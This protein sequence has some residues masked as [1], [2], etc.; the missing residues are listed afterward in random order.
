[1]SLKT[2]KWLSLSLSYP[3]SNE[4]DF[5]EMLFMSGVFALIFVCSIRIWSL[6]RLSHII[7]NLYSM[8]FSTLITERELLQGLAQRPVLVSGTNSFRRFRKTYLGVQSFR[9]R[10]LC[11]RPFMSIYVNIVNFS[12]VIMITFVSCIMNSIF[13]FHF[14]VLLEHTNRYY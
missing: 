8:S 14:P 1:M 13:H 3:L 2:M 5:C 9:G 11:K 12:L 7:N 10:C 4:V 6:V